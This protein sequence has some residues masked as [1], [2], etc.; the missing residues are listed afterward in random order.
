M[1]WKIFFVLTTLFVLLMNIN[2]YNSDFSA[3]SNLQYLVSLLINVGIAFTLGIFY[4]LGWKQQLFSKKA[5]N[6]FL[7][8]F[9][10]SIITFLVASVIQ[11][12]PIIYVQVKNSAAA[13]IGSVIG[14][15]VV[16][17][18]VNILYIPFYVGVYKYKKNF[19]NLISVQKPY[20]KIFSLYCVTILTS[21][22][23]AATTKFAHFALYNLIDYFA[24]FSCIYE[25]IFLIGFSWNVRIFN[26]LFWQITAIPYVLLSIMTPFFISDTFNQDFHIKEIVISNIIPTIITILLYVVCIYIVYRYAYSKKESVWQEISE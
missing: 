19:D 12:Y 7:A 5:A 25:I 18:I 13:I 17:V 23:L 11:A 2:G 9:I 3:I 24:I 10:L 14:T 21:F 4:S 16:A 1:I 15:L 22:V 26:K 6:I 8:M 20:W